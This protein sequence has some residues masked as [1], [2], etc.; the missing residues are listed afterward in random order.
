MSVAVARA[1]PSAASRLG[2][3]LRRI[4]FTLSVVGIMLLLGVVTQT[5]WNP[6][7]DREL[8]ENVAYGYIPLQIGHV[9]TV[10]SGSLYALEP[11]QYLPVAGGFLIVVGFAETMIGTGRVAVAAISSQVVGVV[12]AAAALWLVGALLP[13]YFWAQSRVVDLD[14]GFSAG[15]FGSL[16]AATAV[17]R[18]PWAGRLRI[19][20]VAFGIVMFLYFGLL[21]D[22]E[23]LIAIVFGLLLGPFLFGRRP[24][25]AFPRMSRRE[26]RIIAAWAL[27][28]SVLVRLGLYLD[29]FDGPLGAS[30]HNDSPAFLII[31]TVVCLV[32]ANEL[33]RGKRVAWWFSIAYL[34]VIGVGLI[35]ALI[36][37]LV[38]ASSSPIGLLGDFL[39][40]LAVEMFIWVVLAGILLLGRGAFASPTRRRLRRSGGGSQDARTFAIQTLRANGGTMLS[41]MTTWDA[42]QWY[43]PS[44]RPAHQGD[45]G[46]DFD[47]AGSYVAYQLHQGC[48]VG[49][50]DPIAATP[51][52]RLAVLD[53][54]VDYWEGIGRV[55]CL[56]SV[57]Q[58]TADWALARGWQAVVVAQ[59]AIIDLPTLEFKG[60]PWQDI[61]T[62]LNRAG[63]EGVQFVSGPLGGMPRG[64]QSQVRAISEDW[65]GGKSLP[66]MGFTLGGID[67]ALD[68]AVRVGL[69]IDSE[70]TVHGVTSWLPVFSAGGG[71][72][73]WTLDV[74]RRLPDGFRPTTEFMI[75]SAC[76]EFQ[77]E[78]ADSVSLSGAPLAHG[79]GAGDGTALES[80]L[81]WMGSAMEPLYGFRSLET[82]KQKFRPRDNP[83][84]LVFRDESELP[85]IGLALTK[86]YLPGASWWNLAAAGLRATK[87]VQ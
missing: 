47:G 42:N 70:R 77:Q 71:I 21:W 75:A 26:W 22:L 31:I 3:V 58:Q 5:L 74:M 46:L 9:W 23:H 18:R 84:Y 30:V 1:G 27:V 29:P 57:T 72:S 41:W 43:F 11:V 38:E 39:P 83:L 59:E 55:P 79:P 65:V 45:R 32:L 69:A 80:L 34:A 53:S 64:I 36:D 49:L 19:L 82:F 62:A 56:F 14:V 44:T 20:L 6:L 87:E 17:I 51:E 67:E 25:L 37:L 2:S 24:R 73:A 48:A 28:A 66:E 76:L 60:K 15:M 16:A 40:S 13:D 86:A 12:G 85:R 81:D 78:G 8:F 61:R 52:L 54:Y 63:K 4:P 35:G 50:T 7:K 10:V 68:P 33:R